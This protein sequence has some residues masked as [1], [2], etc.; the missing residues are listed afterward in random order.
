[1]KIFTS[2]C[3]SQHLRIGIKLDFAVGR[4]QVGTA[5]LLRSQGH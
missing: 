2:V 4:K 5:A 1:M 3:L